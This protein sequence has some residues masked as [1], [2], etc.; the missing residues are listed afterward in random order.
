MAL[1]SPLPAIRRE[2]QAFVAGFGLVPA[3]VF[4]VAGIAL[5]LDHYYGGKKF[6]ER[7][8][9][10]P[11]GGLFD[12]SRRDLA[13]LRCLYWE[14]SPFVTLV[15]FPAA[16]LATAG[17]FAPAQRIPSQGFCLGDWRFGLKAAALFYAVMI[18]ILAAVVWSPDFQAKYPLC[19]EAARS[20]A[21]FV[22]YEAGLWLYFFAWEYFFRGF[23]TFSLERS[24]GAWAVFIQML[25]FVAVHFDKPDLEALSSVFGGLALGY[26]A[27]RTRSFLYG[28]LL[29]AAV[30]S[31]FDVMVLTVKGFG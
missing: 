11:L 16:S 27:L 7:N 18:V 12:L 15:L 23:L 25:P 28:A 10:E 2:L 1:A 21:R 8:L 31:T 13:F 14:I 3:T 29:H 17:R 4:V 5:C 6:F 9:A 26:L 20:I 22:A 19:D 24:F 30:H